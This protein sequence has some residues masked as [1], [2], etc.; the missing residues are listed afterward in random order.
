MEQKLT[1]SVVKDLLPNY[2]EKLTSEETNQEIDQHLSECESCTKV[3]EE[4]QTEVPSEDLM[5]EAKNL[6]KF[7]RK[8]K[9]I[10]AL[11]SGLMVMLIL[12]IVVNVIVDLAINH[13]ITWSMIVIAG[14]VLVMCVTAILIWGGKNRFI[15]ALACFSV[16]TFLVL[17]TIS[18][19]CYAS[20]YDNSWFK[21]VAAPIALIWIGVLWAGVFAYRILKWNFWAA[22]CVILVLAIP[23]NFYTNLVASSAT[24]SERMQSLDTM[25]NT[26]SYCA[27]ALVFLVIAF[28]RKG[29]RI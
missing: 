19:F 15:R 23:A 12:G 21:A 24:V 4:M 2:I 5:T 26:L 1:C 18:V 22:I 13:R 29:K 27:G 10:S 14:V 17:Y 16:L 28:I 20:G 9:V 7:L 25:I 8:T 6:S 3:Y 11:K